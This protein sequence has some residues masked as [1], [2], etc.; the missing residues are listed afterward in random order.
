[1]SK[2][3]DLTGQ[4]FEKLTAIRPVGVNKCGQKLW[5]CICNCGNT[6]IVASSNLRRGS[7]RSC[8]CLMWPVKDLTGQKFGKLQVLYRVKE[9]GHGK[10]RSARWLCRCECGRETVVDSSSLKSGNT[11]SCADCSWGS[12]AFDDDCV[13]GHFEDGAIMLIDYADYPM[14]KQHRWWLDKGSGYFATSQDGK[15]LFLRRMLMPDRE[16][17]VCDHINR[18]KLDNRR[19][20]LR[21]ATSKENSRNRSMPKNNTSGYIGVSWHIQN[22]KYI[23]QVKTDGRTHNLGYF[24]TAEAAARARDKAALFYFGEFA[25]LN[26]GGGQNEARTNR[27]GEE[28]HAADVAV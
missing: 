28:I 8:G 2:M 5:E 12:Y 16:G 1:M 10:R 3:I 15:T 27:T 22:K 21:Y 19:S 13:I 26:F 18:D 14:V 7:T 23:A 9:K 24:D 17:L 6:T 25:N 20:N 4:K 11:K